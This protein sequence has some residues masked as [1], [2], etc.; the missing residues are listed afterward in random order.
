MRLS[1][2]KPR[3]MV[4]MACIIALGAM[5]AWATPSNAG[6]PQTT[7]IASSGLVGSWLVLNFDGE[8]FIEFRADGTGAIR[9][10]DE[11][12]PFSYTVNAS[13]TP[14]WIDLVSEGDTIKTIYE[15]IGK[16]SLRLVEDISEDR[17]RDFGEDP[18]LLSRALDMPVEEAPTEAFLGRYE[19]MGDS[20]YF[21]IE[22]R[23]DGSGLV[24]GMDYPEE[25]RGL[26]WRREGALMEMT[27]G[28]I[29]IRFRIADGMTIRGPSDGTANTGRIYYRKDPASQR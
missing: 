27:I 8:A 20:R 28:D 21:A 14:H 15:L 4:A 17:P 18:L 10:G 3:T 19:A 1:N 25:G 6:K 12:Y 2:G 7:D 23:A 13:L 9:Q 26:D 16:D 29:R 11:A 24:Y 5:G 22:L